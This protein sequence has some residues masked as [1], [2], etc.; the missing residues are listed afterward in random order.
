MPGVVGITADFGMLG[1]RELNQLYQEFELAKRLRPEFA[2]ATTYT[3]TPQTRDRSQWR[4]LQQVSR[5]SGSSL[6]LAYSDDARDGVRVMLRE[7]RADVNYEL[8]SADRGRLGVLRGADL[9]EQGLDI[10]P[11]PESAA[12]VLILEPT[13]ATGRVK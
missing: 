8:R 7:I 3:L 6:I 2:D 5:H 12:Q 11:A 1:E 9:M 10:R 4:V 13:A